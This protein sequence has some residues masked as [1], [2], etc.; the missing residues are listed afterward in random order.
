VNYI[1]PSGAIGLY[2]SDWVAV[3]KTIKAKV[4][5]II[6]TK[7]GI[8][9]GTEAKDASIDGCCTDVSAQTDAQWRYIR[10]NQDDSRKWMYQ[11]LRTC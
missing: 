8:C 5:W 6:E 3:Q 7:N 11:D 1:K 4:N 9:E 2:Y 10:V